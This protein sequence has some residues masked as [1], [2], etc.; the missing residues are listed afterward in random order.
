[1]QLF[2]V[3]CV[4]FL[5]H[6]GL[7]LVYPMFSSLLFQTEGSFVDPE[8]SNAARGL[9]FGL[10]L[11]APAITAFFSGPILGALSDQKGRRP[12]YLCS[13]TVAVIGYCLCMVGIWLQSL[14]FLIIAR[15]VVGVSLGNGAVVS[16]TIV[17]V[18]NEHNKTK[19]F[20]LYCMASGV[21]FAVGPFLGGW[22][23]TFG[24][25]VP[26]FVAGIAVFINL[27]LM[28]GLFQ[29]TNLVRTGTSIDITKGLSHLKNAFRIPELRT[30]FAGVALFCFGWSLFYEFLPVVWITDYGLSLK[31]VGFFFAF[32]S[33]VFALSSGV[34]IRPIA[35][36][37]SP[38]VVFCGSSL[39]IACFMVFSLF[40]PSACWIWVY[41]GAVNFF[42]ALGFPT[43]TTIVSDS[44]EKDSQGEILGVLESIQ[45]TAFGMSP[46]IAGFLLGFHIHM[47]LALGATSLGMAAL[48]LVRSRTRAQVQ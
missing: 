11:S 26:F 38:R 25:I 22:L 19:N 33:S 1:M 21:G 12:L 48:I 23:S 37:F 13:I 36:R 46:L 8:M 41:V 9:F 27:V 5:D 6:V 17:D 15:S 29:E 34:L 43:Y 42:A 3:L 4:I 44:V 39:A 20:G 2:L 18:S 35:D 16:A 30:T 10:L 45:A 24:L 32:G 28:Y 14:L 47:P 31:E 40:R 7:G